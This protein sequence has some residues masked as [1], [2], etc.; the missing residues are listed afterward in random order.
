MKY[1]T[2]R[3]LM[4]WISL[5]KEASSN[6]EPH[7]L[8]QYTWLIMPSLKIFI[9]LFPRKHKQEEQPRGRGAGGR[10]RLPIE[11]GAWCKAG[12]QDLEIMTWAKG[13]RSTEWATQGPQLHPFLKVQMWDEIRLMPLWNAMMLFGYEWLAIHPVILRPIST[14]KSLEIIK[15]YTDPT[16]PHWVTPKLS[17]SASIEAGLQNL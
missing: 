5:K 7:I 10:S 6:Q 13:R 3:I 15:K 14:S 17:K 1:N 2:N 16:Y 9:Y 12:S 8:L 11:Q 4:K